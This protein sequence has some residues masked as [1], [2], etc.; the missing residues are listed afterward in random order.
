MGGVVIG[1]CCGRPGRLS[2]TAVR[3]ALA[4]PGD[5]AGKRAAHAFGAVPD[6]VVGASALSSSRAAGAGRG[7]G[8]RTAE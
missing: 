7:G 6:I 4:F 1:R 8:R 2:R 5:A 3:D